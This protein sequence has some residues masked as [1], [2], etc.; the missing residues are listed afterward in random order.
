MKTIMPKNK[1]KQ[2][3]AAQR[4]IICFDVIHELKLSLETLDYKIS[5]G[6]CTEEQAIKR[7]KVII[8]KSMSKVE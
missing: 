6:E 4:Q 7:L 2:K 1:E 8:N 3:N 5:R